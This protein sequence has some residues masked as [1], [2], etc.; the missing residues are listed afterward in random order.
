MYLTGKRLA[1]K[2]PELNAV[3]V[4]WWIVWFII[5]VTILAFLTVFFDRYFSMKYISV[6]L[7]FAW[8]VLTYYV[9]EAIVIDSINPL[10]A[11]RNSTK[12][13]RQTFLEIVGAG[14]LLFLIGLPVEGLTISLRQ[15]AFELSRLQISYLMAGLAMYI[16]FRSILG[17]VSKTILYLLSKKELPASF[18]EN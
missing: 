3:V 15:Y 6:V 9:K 18:L 2:K 10:A 16:V 17:S 8:A 14:I 13:F 4:F 5:S 1:K 11:L 12:A 7:G